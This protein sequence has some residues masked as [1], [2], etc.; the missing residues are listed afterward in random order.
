MIIALKVLAL[1]ALLPSTF[2]T[3]MFVVFSWMYD[4]G[5]YKWTAAVLQI[6][7]IAAWM[8]WMMWLV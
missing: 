1:L 7:V 2:Y 4:K 3:L 5:W 8:M 6:A